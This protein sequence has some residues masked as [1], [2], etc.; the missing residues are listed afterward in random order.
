LFSAFT[1]WGGFRWLPGRSQAHLRR[2]QRLDVRIVG[3]GI[4]EDVRSPDV[5]LPRRRGFL[6]RGRSWPAPAA[7]MGT[8]RH[9][10]GTPRRTRCRARCGVHVRPLRHQLAVPGSD[11]NW[12][13]GPVDQLAMQCYG[14]AGTLRRAHHR[15]AIARRSGLGGLAGGGGRSGASTARASWSRHRKSWE[16]TSF[17]AVIDKLGSRNDQRE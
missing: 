15:R 16:S 3:A 13:A 7:S 5:T 4:L 6:R 9:R 11:E 14:S 12:G 8:D 17:R 1:T 2:G 10:L